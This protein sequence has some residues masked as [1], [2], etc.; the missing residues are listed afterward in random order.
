[1]NLSYELIKDVK[2]NSCFCHFDGQLYLWYDLYRCRL[3]NGH[4][5]F[6]NKCDVTDTLLPYGA[7]EISF[8]PVQPTK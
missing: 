7:A 5:L 3:Q 1:M 6:V 8:Q 4:I 2:R